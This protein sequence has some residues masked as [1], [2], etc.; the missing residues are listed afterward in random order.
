MRSKKNDS[1]FVNVQKT[2]TTSTLLNMEEMNKNWV[3]VS[4]LWRFGPNHTC[5]N[6]LLWLFINRYKTYVRSEI[7]L[8]QFSET[9]TNSQGLATNSVQFTIASTSNELSF[10][11]PLFAWKDFPKISNSLHY[12]QPFSPLSKK[13]LN[14]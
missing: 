7:V 11:T 3:G 10:C 13:I 8:W 6:T 9:V 2:A 1:F 5:C 14:L 12:F 4:L